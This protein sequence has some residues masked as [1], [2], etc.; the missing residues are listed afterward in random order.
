MSELK[1]IGANLFLNP[2]GELR[3]GVRVL[4][5]FFALIVFVTVL[6]VIVGIIGVLFPQ[7]RELLPGGARLADLPPYKAVIA[8]GIERTML[9]VG[10]LAAS[11]ICARFLEHRSFGSTGYKFHKGWLRDF[12]LGSALGTVTLCFAVAIATIAGA[13]SF[14]SQSHSAGFIAGSFAGAFLVFLIAAA[15]E[16]ALIRGFAFQA[17]THN[18]GPVVALVSTSVLFGALH[19]GNDDVTTLSTINTVL[20]GVWLGAAYLV[21]RS[22]WLATALH[23]SWN[24]VMAFVFGLP[25]SGFTVY[26]STAILDGTGSNPVWISGGA[27]GPEGGIAATIA[28]II[29]TLIIWKSGLFKPAEDMLAA[30]KHDSILTKTPSII[31]QDDIEARIPD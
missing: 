24:L 29:C 28:V 16:E 26:K 18:L 25:V 12:L 5:F 20:A 15:F 17:I 10:T 8:M 3:C 31:P 11:A 23:Y 21:T 9:L 4:A 13:M 1:N 6:G 27:Y 30:I 19:L 22:L 2:E 7:S 14:T